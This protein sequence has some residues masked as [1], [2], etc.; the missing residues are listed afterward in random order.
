MAARGSFP[1]PVVDSTPDVDSTFEVINVAV[2][3]TQEDVEVSLTVRTDD[4]DLVQLLESRAVRHS[5]RWTCTSTISTDEVAPQVTGRT[6]DGWILAMSIDQQRIR[7]NVDA[8]VR[9]IATEPI[10]GFQWSG[11][12]PDYG[13]ASFSVQTGDLIADGGSFT[14]SADKLYDPL[15][16]P[17]GSCFQF[18][19][20]VQLGKGIR[21]TFMAEH[22]VVVSLPSATYD[23]LVRASGRPDL[24]IATVV[25]PALMET[26]S[27][28]KDN[29]AEDQ[30]EP[31]D[32]RGWYVAIC[33]MVDEIGGFDNSPLVLA[34]EILENPIDRLLTAFDTD[35]DDE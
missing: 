15:D 32:D 33:A 7:G 12:H 5:I 11:Q 20:D 25:L 4:V 34:Q 24:Q 14:F 6:A 10:H 29:R 13:G 26:L 17:I 8:D 35:G 9:V 27:F 31:L 21:V 22:A 30:P 3:P 16:P 1:H 18:H 19:R 2:A 28:I 23:G